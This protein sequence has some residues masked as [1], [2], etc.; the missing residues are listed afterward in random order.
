MSAGADRIDTAIGPFAGGTSHP[1]VS[2]VAKF[3]ELM[4]FEHDIDLSHVYKAAKKLREIRKTLAQFDKWKDEVPE[5]IPYPLPP[6]VTDKMEIIVSLVKD[7]KFTEARDKTVELMSSLGY[8][9]P[10]ETQLQSQV[11]GGMLSN[12]RT[13][14]STVGQ[15]EKLPKILEEV[16]QVR[17][18]VGYPPL[19]T[20]SS[21]IIGAQASFN[22]ETADRYSVCSREFKDMI[23]G[24]YGK[25]GIID[26]DFITRVAKTTQRYDQR[27][28]FY[29]KSAPLTEDDGLNP[30][31][32]I[33][34]HRDLLLYLM[35]P[36]PA[37]DFFG[38]AGGA[39]S[40]AKLH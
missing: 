28:G 11:P 37:K 29:V 13:Q 6:T 22:V 21:Q 26:D 32:F 25:P 1:P 14:L 27:S 5:P 40:G 12:L 3:A 39:G 19:V 36:G 31:P 18:D 10:D 23:C 2:L 35:L 20:P 17:K 9:V 24:R 38:E 34:N 7:K 8:P 33:H 15:L 16:Q 4:G 30:P